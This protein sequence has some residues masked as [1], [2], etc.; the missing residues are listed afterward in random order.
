MRKEIE[1]LRE[2][3]ERAELGGGIKEIE[4]VHQQGKLT[5]RERLEIFYDPGTFRE[6]NLW[7]KPTFTGFPQI[8]N[9]ELSGDAVVTGIGKVNGRPVCVYAHNATEVA[10]TQASVQNAKVSRLMS[11]A[12]K[13]GIPYVALNDS[14]G[15]RI[16]D[17][18]GKET[19]RGISYDMDSWYTPATTLGAVPTITVTLG[20]SYAGSAYSPMLA[21]V[22]FM[23]NKPYCHMS[24]ASPEVIRT[25]TSVK[26]T[27]DEIGSAL[28][29][30]EVTGSCDYM[31]ESDK[32][33]ILAAKELLSYLP[34]NC[35]KK[36]PILDLGDDPKRTDDE[37][38]DMIPLDLSSYD[39]HNII[40]R[41]VDCGQ[42]LELKERYAQNVI[43]AFARIGGRSVGIVANNPAHLDG[44]IDTKSS[45]KMA[46]FVRYCDS[47]NVPLIFLV[48]TPGYLPAPEQEY[49]GYAR[50]AAMA[51]YA[52]CEATVPKILIYLGKGYG[53]GIFGMGTRL[54]D[55][56]VVLAWP[57]ARLQLVSPE[58]AVEVIYEKR[59]RQAENGDSLRNELLEEVKTKFYSVYHWGELLSLDDIIDPK[60]TRPYLALMLEMI[61]AK[62]PVTRFHKKHGN[63]PL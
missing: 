13:W 5:V 44:A 17:T 41:I 42:Y 27:R 14:G 43:T 16:F 35:W 55:F 7:A 31:G 39:M 60:D 46:R 33:C 34:D 52:Y 54:M 38:G 30:A 12:V 26:V 40:K 58:E 19:G 56:D 23:V 20:P 50:R 47:F 4:R 21:D 37:L 9:R 48:D 62:K 29:H 32:D 15:V 53:D 45:V 1:Y 18:V 6:F 24:L 49:D 61:E 57:S 10:G 36:P 2:R 25:V 11:T 3:R 59:L 8:D 22:L 28:L 51:I 63:I